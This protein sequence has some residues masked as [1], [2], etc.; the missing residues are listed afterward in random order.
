MPAEWEP[1]RAVHLAWPANKEDWPGKFQPIPWVITEIIRQATAEGGRVFLAAVSERHAAQAR[2]FLLRV[3]VDAARVDIVVRPLDRGW[4]R[5]ISPF[6][7]TGPKGARAAVRF[8]FNGW[9]KY[10]NH[11]LDDQWPA[12]STKERGWPLVEAVWNGAPVVL[13]GGAVDSNGR[14][15]L[16]TTEECL[17]DPETQTR[18]PGFTRKDYEGLF[19]KWLGIRQ[20]IWLGKGIAGDDTHGHVDDLCRFVNP[21][22]VVLCREPD[23]KDANHRALEENRERLQGVRLANG[24]S[25]DVVELPMPAPVVFDGMRLP[26]SYANFLIAYGRVIVPTFNDPNDRK[27]LG[28]LAELFPDRVVAGVHAVDLVW[29]LGT[30]HCLSHEEP[31]VSG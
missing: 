24:Q 31:E 13:E 19:R 15:A 4:M 10:G 18:N 3:E 23:G 28:I 8:R 1:Q 29:G 20:V 2:R 14:G 12:F 22:T 9:A 27:A 17:L 5:D 30:V 7:V 6:F 25:L 26:A 16:L 11:K 21:N